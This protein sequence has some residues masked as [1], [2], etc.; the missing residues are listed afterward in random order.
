LAGAAASLAVD[1]PLPP[2]GRCPPRQA[3]GGAPI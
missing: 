1:L 2:M 3:G